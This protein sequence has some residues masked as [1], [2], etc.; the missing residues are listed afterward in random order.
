MILVAGTKFISL[1]SYNLDFHFW[2]DVDVSSW[3]V[4]KESSKLSIN[5]KG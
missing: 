2:L 1:N 5:L 4:M 3:H